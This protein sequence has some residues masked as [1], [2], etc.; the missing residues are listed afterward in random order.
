MANYYMYGEIP[1]VSLEDYGDAMGGLGSFAPRGE[2]ISGLPFTMPD[3]DRSYVPRGEDVPVMPFVPPAT[4][5]FE[6]P[7]SPLT[8]VAKGM[9]GGK[10][11]YT[12]EEM[13]EIL[14]NSGLMG[15]ATGPA[16]TQVFDEPVYTP[17]GAVSYT[18]LTLPTKA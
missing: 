16:P 5:D 10:D 12:P 9:T 11:R 8:S 3:E 18:H 1:G 17:R 6:A 14:K 4:Y 2:V 15:S 7:Q 13:A